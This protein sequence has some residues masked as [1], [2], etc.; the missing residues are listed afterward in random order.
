MAMAHDAQMLKA[1]KGGAAQKAVEVACLLLT[2]L[3]LVACMAFELPSA[4][5]LTLAAAVAAL[6][7]FFAGWERSQPGL[8]QMLPA[9]VL[10]AAAV[11]GRI[12]FA[13]APNVQPVTALCVI[14]GAVFGR[15]T[16]FMV[17]AVTGLV[18]SLFLGIGAWTPWQMYAWGTVGYF[19]GILFSRRLADGVSGPASLKRDSIVAV[20]A[21][22]FL[23][24][25]AYGFVMNTWMLVGFLGSS[26]LPSFVAV[27][28]AGV[29][30]DVAHAISTVAFLG[31]LYVPLSSRLVRISIRYA[32]D[33]A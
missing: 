20:L 6:V 25:F 23:A 14:A 21:Y 2:P 29:A 28:G 11:A 17:G 22:G 33:G 19:A 16:G 3:A 27:Y 5:L 10:S 1:R 9:A 24:S 18:S 12:V 15:R 31:L 30:F 7:M 32:L 8:R 4:G 26:G 13:A